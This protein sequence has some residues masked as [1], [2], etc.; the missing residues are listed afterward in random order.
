V[1]SSSPISE[2]LIVEEYKQLKQEQIQRIHSRDTFVNLTIVAVGAIAA[3]TFNAKIARPQALMAIPWVTAT[4]GWTFIVN[5]LKI[6]RIANY[7]DQLISAHIDGPNW[8]NW[9][10][11]DD[12]SW[13]EHRVVG[14]IIQMVIFVL[15][16]IISVCTYPYLRPRIDSLKSWEYVLVGSGWSTGILLTIAIVSVSRQRRSIPK[17][18]K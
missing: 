4:L 7:L 13:I 17:L 2:T 8:D 16:T 15:P 3:V 12:R 14:T 11:G 5:D 18:I 6:A 10:R 1:P 9:R